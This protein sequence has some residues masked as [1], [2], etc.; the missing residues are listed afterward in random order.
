MTRRMGAVALVVVVGFA[1]CC[2][3]E[4]ERFDIFVSPDGVIRTPQAALAKVRELRRSGAIATNQTARIGFAAG[5]YELGEELRIGSEDSPVELKGA[6][7]GGTVFSG[8][9]KVGPFTAGADGVWRAKV[10]DGFVFE[11]FWVNGQRAQIAREPNEFYHYIL[12]EADEGKDPVTGKLRDLGRI[13]LTTDKKAVECLAGLSAKE[14]GEAMV[15]VWW[16]WETEWRRPYFADA[17]NN[18]IYLTYPLTRAIFM[19]PKYCPRVTIENTRKALDAP[20]EWFL[21]RTKSEVL[22]IPREGEDIATAVGVAPVVKRFLFVDK[23]DTVWIDGI[24]F[25]YNSWIMPKEGF[26]GSQSA[27]GAD[28]SIEVSESRNVR[29]A[30]CRV[31]HTANY[32]LWFKD[33]TKDSEVRH[34]WFEDLGAGGIRLG[35]RT[36]SKAKPNWIVERIRVDDNIIFRGGRVTPA[37]TAIYGQFFR[38]SVITHN[39]VCDMYYSGICSGW[40]WGYAEH[41]NRNN[42]YSWNHFRHLGKGVLSDMGYVYSLGD[43][44]GSIVTGNVG[45]EMYSYGY[46]GSGG[47]GLYPDEGTRGMLYTSNLVFHTK[48]SALS[49]HY[50]R[51]NFFHNNIFAFN[52]KPGISVAGRWRPED[53]TSLVCSNNVFCWGKEQAA[54]HGSIGN[55]KGPTK[56]LVFGSNLWWSPDGVKDDDFNGGSFSDWQKAGMDRGSVVADPL[57]V[58][59]KKGDFR[60]QPGSPAFKIGFKA[61]DYSLAGVRKEDKVWRAKAAALVPEPLRVAPVP[62][63]NPGTRSYK[64]GF[65]G[66]AVGSTPG[67]LSCR[68]VVKVSNREA[69]HGKHSLFLQDSKDQRSFYPHFAKS[70]KITG[71]R[72][73][74]RFSIRCDEK[75]DCQVETREYSKQ[76]RN[77]VYSSGSWIEVKDGRFRILDAKGRTEVPFY[78]PNAWMDVTMVLRP[79]SNV[80][81]SWDVT[82]VSEDGQTFER[83]G[84]HYRGGDCKNPTW[85]GFMSNAQHETVAYIDD[86]SIESR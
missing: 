11:Q 65:E 32:G 27:C 69:R 5:E 12:G 62:P 24:T 36:W 20:G 42:E 49:Q 25:M 46:T 59:W 13:L 67:S 6:K 33:N 52:T 26:R 35:A 61:W 76:A 7:D 16:A 43:H 57:F 47:T 53:H 71:E 66:N 74:I 44:R 55:G 60:L 37:G 63:T 45:E 75:A 8:G 64:T 78:R 31:E 58:D 38:E 77:G 4:K 83:K 10:P 21:D 40:C 30:N 50:G 80:K 39:E 51:D 84:M 9:R 14:L 23:A 79:T 86:L 70:F 81:V 3:C 28:A 48:T 18:G 19:W 15:H 56:D 2:R 29:F 85:F 17:G 73:E 54:W 34:S 22:Y 82:V 68:G 1:G 41:P 72:T